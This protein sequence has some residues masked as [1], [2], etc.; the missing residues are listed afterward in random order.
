MKLNVLLYIPVQGL[1]S[2]ADRHMHTGKPWQNLGGLAWYDNRA[3]WYD[4]VTMRFTAPDPLAEKYLETSPWA[5]CENNPVNIK[6]LSGLNWYRTSDGD[7]IWDSDVTSQYNTPLGCIY[8]GEKY[9]GISIKQYNAKNHGLSINIEYQS[10]SDEKMRWIQ[11]ITTN[12]P[13][14]GANNQYLDP[15]PNDD[16]K[17]FYYT[18]EELNSFVDLENHRICFVDNPERPN[19]EDYWKAELSLVKCFSAIVLPKI[20]I[21]YGFHIKN[22]KTNLDHI[23]IVKPS[24]FQIGIINDYN[25]NII[26]EYARGFIFY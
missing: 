24:T 21:S 17:P 11:N 23:K 1:A 22:N 16:D 25:K 3:R 4:P 6:D 9:D 5:F 14:D 13:S 18:D 26:N 10:E 2:V 20:T 12:N 7:V 8:I 15:N 19:D